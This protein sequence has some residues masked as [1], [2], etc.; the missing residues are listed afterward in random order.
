MYSDMCD[1]VL[2][3]EPRVSICSLHTAMNTAS[4]IG[5]NVAHF[6]AVIVP[7]YDVDISV[8]K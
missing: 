5:N 3:S 6:S 4:L 1:D 7:V 8:V 2:V